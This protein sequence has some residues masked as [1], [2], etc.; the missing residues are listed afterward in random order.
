MIGDIVETK[1]KPLEN[2][3]FVCKINPITQEEYLDVM[4]YHFGKAM[5]VNT[6]RYYKTLDKFCYA[7]IEFE[8]QEAC[9]ASIHR[10]LLSMVAILQCCKPY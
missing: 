8:T 6:I 2:V 5:L 4:F 9:I 3:L 1:I 7:F 10:L